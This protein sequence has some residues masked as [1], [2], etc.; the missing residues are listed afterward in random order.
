MKDKISS[1][2]TGISIAGKSL[3]KAIPMQKIVSKPK[4]K[5]QKK[6]KNTYIDV[7]DILCA[8]G[9]SNPAVAHAIKKLLMPGQRGHKN[10]TTDIKEAISALN[11]ALELQLPN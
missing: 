10:A 2:I 4:N 9:V 6:I 7:Y 11:R 8:Y 5:Y 3:Q 1:A